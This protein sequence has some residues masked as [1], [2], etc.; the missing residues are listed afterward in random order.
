MKAACANLQ[1]LQKGTECIRQ[2][3][4]QQCSLRSGSTT[5]STLNILYLECSRKQNST[6]GWIRSKLCSM[7]IRPVWERERES[8]SERERERESVTWIKPSNS[9]RMEKHTSELSLGWA[10]L[11]SLQ[12][13]RDHLTIWKH[14]H[15]SIAIKPSKQ[16][17]LFGPENLS[18]KRAQSTVRKML[19][20]HSMSPMLPPEWGEL[21]KGFGSN[22]HGAS[23]VGWHFVS[24]YAYGFVL[25]LPQTRWSMKSLKRAGHCKANQ[26]PDLW[27]RVQALESYWISA[28]VGRSSLET[29]RVENSAASDVHG[30]VEYRNAFHKPSRTPLPPAGDHIFMHSMDGFIPQLMVREIHHIHHMYQ[31]YRI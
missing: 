2:M 4:E 10:G 23:L 19:T 6:A 12:M 9:R 3:K 13:I 30:V 8:E 22:E 5:T 26:G 17:G 18:G 31:L 28:A 20:D 1:A 27:C 25:S 16:A 7:T 14:Q 24:Q 21:Q 15:F 11:T 29:K